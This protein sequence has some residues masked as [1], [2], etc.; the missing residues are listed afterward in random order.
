MIREKWLG[1][2][3]SRKPQQR[4]SVWWPTGHLNQS[5]D[6]V[7]MFPDRVDCGLEGAAPHWNM[8][9]LDQ[10]YC[11]Y[12]VGDTGKYH[13]WS[14]LFWVMG[15]LINKLIPEHFR[16]G[17]STYCFIEM[18]LQS[19]HASWVMN[20]CDHR[21]LGYRAGFQWERGNPFYKLPFLS[22]TLN[23]KVH[24]GSVESQIQLWVVSAL[25]DCVTRARDTYP[26]NPVWVESTV[27][28]DLG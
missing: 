2:A 17:A 16:I 21:V 13:N 27:H 6:Q 24:L 1:A 12:Q 5:K 10:Q 3:V 23:V 4:S 28:R 19:S 20:R 15:E 9:I 8:F 7:I 22:S 18:I 11:R 25:K 14:H 26:V